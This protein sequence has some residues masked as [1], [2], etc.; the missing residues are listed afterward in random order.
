MYETYLMELGYKGKTGAM[1]LVKLGAKGE[2]RED[3]NS[4]L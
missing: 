2:L 3:G 1:S 4:V